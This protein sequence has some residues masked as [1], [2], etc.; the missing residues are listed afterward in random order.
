MDH[1][2]FKHTIS[3]A[4]SVYSFNIEADP[5]KIVESWNTYWSE[6]EKKAHVLGE[7]CAVAAQWFLKEFAAVPEPSLANISFN[8]LAFGIMWPSFIACPVTLPG[9]IMANAKFHIEQKNNPDAAKEAALYTSL[10]VFTSMSLATL[11]ILLYDSALFAL[12]VAIAIIAAVIS[13]FLIAGYY[14]HEALSNDSDEIN[15]P[16]THNP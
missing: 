8:H 6:T 3:E 14:A 5:C 1:K 10:F 15:C 11:A 4:S 12:T 2:R 7:N 9:R 13:I 16:L